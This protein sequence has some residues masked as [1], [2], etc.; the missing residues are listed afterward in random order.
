MI[1]Q[2][3][4]DHFIVWTLLTYILKHLVNTLFT[5]LIAFSLGIIKEI[6]DQIKNKNFSIKDLVA[7]CIGI[8]VGMLI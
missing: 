6:Y 2:D 8:L 7:D 1:E 3:K 5:I 4:I